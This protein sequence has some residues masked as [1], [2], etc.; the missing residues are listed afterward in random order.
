MLLTLRNIILPF[1]LTIQ[2]AYSWTCYYRAQLLEY[3][4]N[5]GLMIHGFIISVVTLVAIYFLWYYK[6]KW[7]AIDRIVFVLWLILGSPVT[8]VFAA[9]Y[10]QDIFRTTLAT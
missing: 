5:Y 9:I 8:F 2:T 4:D 3:D 1:V 10:Y 6:A 7:I